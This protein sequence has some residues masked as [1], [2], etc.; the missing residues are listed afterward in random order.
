MCASVIQLSINSCSG[1]QLRLLHVN[2][3]YI[4]HACYGEKGAAACSMYKPCTLEATMIEWQSLSVK[5]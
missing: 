4:V 3:T 1:Q 2:S 5:G